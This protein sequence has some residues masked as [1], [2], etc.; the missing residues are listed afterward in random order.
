M[1]LNTFGDM[2]LDRLVREIGSVFKPSPKSPAQKRIKD[3]GAQSSQPREIS[4]T[5]PFS[6]AQLGWLHKALS[7]A[8]VA[9]LQA[10]GEAVESR[11]VIVE[12]SVGDVN[13]RTSNVEDQT[14]SLEVFEVDER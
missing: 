5:V 4:P 3:E 1:A 8:Q 6:S 11:V 13:T 2:K 14:A 7:L 12:T 9:S 10:F